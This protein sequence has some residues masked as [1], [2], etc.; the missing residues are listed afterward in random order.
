[1]KYL[2][3]RVCPFHAP[4]TQLTALFWVFLGFFLRVC[5]VCAL[6]PPHTL[7]PIALTKKTKRSEAFGSGKSFKRFL[8]EGV[9]F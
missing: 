4:P 2:G 8:S 9:P 7:P 5:L 3:K 6:A 1:M